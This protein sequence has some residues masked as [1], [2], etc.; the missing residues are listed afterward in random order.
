MFGLVEVND[1]SPAVAQHHQDKQNLEPDGRHGEK[2]DGDDMS[3]N[4]HE[5][6]VQP[7]SI[8]IDLVSTHFSQRQKQRSSMTLSRYTV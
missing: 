8:T 3:V 7:F 1:T 5:G 6:D 2:V 4:E